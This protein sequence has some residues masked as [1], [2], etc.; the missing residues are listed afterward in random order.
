MLRADAI[1]QSGLRPQSRRRRVARKGRNWWI[2]VLAVD[3]KDETIYLCEATIAQKPKYMLQR[4]RAW[5]AHWQEICKTLFRLTQAPD[6]WR[7]KPWIFAPDFLKPKIEGG[8]AA[9]PDLPFDTNGRRLRTSCLGSARNVPQYGP[10]T[11]PDCKKD[12]GGSGINRLPQRLNGYLQMENFVVHPVRR[13]ASGQMP[14]CLLIAEVIDEPAVH[15]ERS[16][17]PPGF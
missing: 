2:D 13:G 14:A 17:E 3:F 8:I 1:R 10:V 16:V 6:T 4:L 9:I 5:T 11:R 15:P 12:A 7:V